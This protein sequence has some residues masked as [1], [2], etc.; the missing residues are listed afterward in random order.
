MKKLIMLASA[1]LASAGCNRGGGSGDQYGTT[2]NRF[3][4]N[5]N[6]QSRRRQKQEFPDHRENRTWLDTFTSREQVLFSSLDETS[7]R[8]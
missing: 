5:W 7:S 1:M 3:H 6:E 4:K 2:E 8:R